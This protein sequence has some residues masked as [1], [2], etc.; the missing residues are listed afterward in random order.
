M[1]KIM[2]KG[3]VS[4][5]IPTYNR[6]GLIERAVDSVLDQDYRQIEVIVV[7]DG[8]LTILPRGWPSDIGTT[9][10]SAFSD[11]Q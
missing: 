10:E 5:V 1:G 9:R 11:S 6:A 4:V 7:D 8:S 2:E 3:L